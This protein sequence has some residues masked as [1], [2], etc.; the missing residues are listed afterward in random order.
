M[1]CNPDRVL[2]LD[3]LAVNVDAACSFG[4]RSEQVR[5]LDEVVTVLKDSGLLAS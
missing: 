1:L 5:G 4:F 2:F 3:D